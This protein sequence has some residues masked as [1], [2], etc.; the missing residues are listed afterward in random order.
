V[1]E[2][3]KMQRADLIA[4]GF[5]ND[6]N[7]PD[8]VFTHGFGQIPGNQGAPRLMLNST[9]DYQA[10]LV[11]LEGSSANKFAIGAK[12]TLTDANDAMMGYRVQ[13]LNSN[14]HQNTH[15]MHFGLGEFTAP[16]HLKIE[17]P[18]GKT[19]SHTF[20]EPGRYEVKQ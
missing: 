1:R 9:S 5:F 10:L 3:D 17:W 8:I 11:N 13:G 2:R 14:I 19:T 4:H 6:D 20:S 16:Y 12:L 7:Q 15:W 18:D